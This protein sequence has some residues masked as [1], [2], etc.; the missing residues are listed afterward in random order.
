MLH[1]HSSGV[2]LEGAGLG[3][4]PAGGLHLDRPSHAVG[5]LQRDAVELLGSFLLHF[6]P[7]Y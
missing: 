6:G 2:K 4:L 3:V 1:P 5:E 7:F